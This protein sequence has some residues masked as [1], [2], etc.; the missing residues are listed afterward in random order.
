MKALCF[1]V[2]QKGN[3]Q[4]RYFLFNKIQK[5]ETHPNEG[6]TAFSLKYLLSRS[7]ISLMT[8][9]DPESWKLL[10]IIITV[11]KNRFQMNWKVFPPNYSSPPQPALRTIDC[12]SFAKRNTTIDQPN[13]WRN[14]SQ[15][16]PSPRAK[17]F[18]SFLDKPTQNLMSHQL[19]NYSSRFYRHTIPRLERSRRQPVTAIYSFSL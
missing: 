15:I 18:F 16:T 17:T 13:P 5:D 11:S 12:S 6:N 14:F 1:H 7:L 8:S 2:T 4:L 3:L 19:Q 10:R 9:Y